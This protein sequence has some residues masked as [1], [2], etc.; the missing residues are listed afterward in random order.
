MIDETSARVTEGSPRRYADSA[1][2][3]VIISG[4]E[5]R[6]VPGHYASESVA[7]VLETII[8]ATQDLLIE[9]AMSGTDTRSLIAL[10]LP[11]MDGLDSWYEGFKAE[12]AETA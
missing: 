4:I 2:I 7:V 10:V 9:C 11:L 8:G 5:G 6:G 3:E 1:L 12:P